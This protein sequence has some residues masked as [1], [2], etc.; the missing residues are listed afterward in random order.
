MSS[1]PLHPVE[2]DAAVLPLRTRR[3]EAPLRFRLFYHSVV[4]DWS[5]GNAHFLRG[6]ACE[7][8]RRGH[9]VRIFEPRDGWSLR[10]LK[11][12]SGAAEA[13]DAYRAVFPGLRSTPYDPARPNLDRALDGADVVLVHEWTDPDIVEGIGRI[14]R[15]SRFRALFHDTHHR[16]VT[17]PDEIGRF[18]LDAYDGVLAYGEVL[19]DVYRR[20]GWGRRVWT[21]HEAADVRVFRPMRAPLEGDIVWIGNWGDDERTEELSAYLLDPARELGLRGSVHGVRYP[22][23]GVRAV[24]RAGL[25]FRGW[26]PN[27]HVP[28]VFARHRVTVHVSRRPYVETLPGIPTIRPFEA[29]ACGI[30]LVTSPWRDVEGLFRAGVDHLVANSPAEMRRYLRLLVNDADA[31]RAIARAGLETVRARHTCA[32]RVDELMGILRELER[33]RPAGVVAHDRVITGR[34][35][36]R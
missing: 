36:A 10:G 6:I 27:V 9:D 12:E 14:R 16:A 26:L 4:S 19:S 30:P 8:M 1:L 18:H 32:H 7:L 15:G 34:A 31:R 20:R 35:A 33:E 22:E 2:G 21:W 5:H 13:L 17:R 29:M 25:R 23:D 28:Q 3:G 11:S 24:E